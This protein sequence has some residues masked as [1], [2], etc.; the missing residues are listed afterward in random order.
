M[1]L[2]GQL[3]TVRQYTQDRAGIE[4]TFQFCRDEGF[5]TIQISGFGPV[6]ARELD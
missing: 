2:G 5:E 4:K 6:D 1:K 3:Y